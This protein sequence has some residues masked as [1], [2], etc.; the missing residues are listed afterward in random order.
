MYAASAAPRDSSISARIASSSRPSCSTSSSVRWAYSL[1]SA[2][3]MTAS[4]A[5]RSIGSV[6]QMSS[7]QSPT[8]AVMQV[9]T[10]SLGWAYSS[11]LRRS[12]TRPE[13]RV[14]VQ[15]W[16]MPIRQP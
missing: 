8:A 14:S 5:G 4:F 16:Q 12:R 15:V 3:A 10:C 6:G 1:T 2:M 13:T 11:P 9:C 7:V